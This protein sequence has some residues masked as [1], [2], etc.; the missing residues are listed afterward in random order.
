MSNNSDRIRQLEKLLQEREQILN[1]K[2]NILHEMKSRIEEQESVE[3][4]LM[5]EIKKLKEDNEK[6]VFKS[7]EISSVDERINELQGELKNKEVE[8]TNNL[9]FELEKQIELKREI[10]FKN[11]E[12]EQNCSQLA[13]TIDNLS[14]KIKFLKREKLNML[15]E[16]NDYIFKNMLVTLSINENTL[17]LNSKYN[18]Y[19]ILLSELTDNK[20]KL[21]WINPKIKNS[22]LIRGKIINKL[23]IK[24]TKLIIS[25]NTNQDDN[26]VIDE[27][28]YTL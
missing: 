22:K 24:N 27:N 8:F 6:T 18:G 9:N 21:E 28:N 14:K 19:G 3:K 5:S 23:E 10:E 4:H 26:L 25:S 15:S 13:D 12:Q 2:E 1:D 11:M 20:F 16:L 17:K 7:R